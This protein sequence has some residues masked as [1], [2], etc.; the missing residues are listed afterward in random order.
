MQ[1]R[2]IFIL[3]AGISGLA[4]AY[5]LSHRSDI[6]EIHVL[7]KNRQAGGWIDSDDSSGFFFEKG[8]RVF[9]TSTSGAFLKLAV[10]IGMDQEMVFSQAHGK[11][12]WREGKMR[13]SPEFSWHLIRGLFKEWRV[14]PLIGQDESV[15]DFACRRFNPYVAKTIFDPMVRGVYG[16]SMKEISIKN[17]FPRLKALEEQYGSVIRGFLKTPKTKGSRLFSFQRGMRSFVR[18]L[19]EQIV[20]Q[21]HYEQEVTAIQRCGQ[22]WAIKTTKETYIADALFSA[23]PSHIL[24]KLFVPQ[25][26]G[27]STRSAT[28]VQLGYN[29]SVL[30]NKGFG[31][32]VAS[33][34][35]EDVLGVVFDSNTFP[36]FNH[37]PQ[38]S[39]L[40]VMLGRDDVGEE[41]ARNLA[42]KALKK[43]LH[44]TDAPAVSL[45]VRA[46]HVFPQFK[47]GHDK[48]IQEIETKTA[49]LWLLGNYLA[50]PGVNDCIA[51]AQSVAESFLREI[52]S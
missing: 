31:Y 52:A 29:R 51:R 38:E 19:E 2:R 4:L 42:L 15:W 47:V 32:L 50:G 30:K 8:P 33:D 23:L 5:Y 34:E 28:L 20:S 22:Q 3:G 43:H 40:T 17:G 49:G 35:N 39:R 41:E 10:E 48:L 6:L 45:V 25:L 37:S 36:Q 18:R 16:G 13:S 21:F 14:K 27:L 46:P 1:K 11:Y 44:I 24:G 9:R 7:E 26:L 12:L